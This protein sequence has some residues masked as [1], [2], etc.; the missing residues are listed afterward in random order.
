MKVNPYKQLTTFFLFQAPP[1]VDILD[2]EEDTLSLNSIRTHLVE[3]KSETV[4]VA[5]KI[6]IDEH[7]H[8]A[9]NETQF[10]YTPIHKTP[11]R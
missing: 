8:I 1:H 6:R 9:H 4:Q 5:G 3:R 11:Y 10:A 2:L 7:H